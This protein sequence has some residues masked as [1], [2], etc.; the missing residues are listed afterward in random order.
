MNGAVNWQEY[1]GLEKGP[2][3]SHAQKNARD[4]PRQPREKIE[5]PPAGITS[6]YDH[7]RDEREKQNANQAR[8]QPIAKV[9]HNER[10]NTGSFNVARQFSRVQGSAILKK[11]NS[12]INVPI[13][14][15]A[16]GT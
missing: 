11:P 15:N 14:N 9:F 5:Q 7:I 2:K 6:L 13:S 3:Q 8:A 1:S 10:I 12:F 16:V 4:R